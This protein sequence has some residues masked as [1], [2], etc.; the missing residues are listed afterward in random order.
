MLTLRLLGT[1]ELW[2]NGSLVPIERRKALALL[3]YLA[4]EPGAHSRERLATLL[5]PD[6]APPAARAGLRRALAE[7]TPTLRPWLIATNERIALQ[8]D[9]A[10]ALDVATFRQQVALPHERAAAVALYR[11]ELLAGFALPDNATFD[12]WLFFQR[13]RLRTELADALDQ[14]SRPEAG[15]PDY[16]PVLEYARR[17]IA[18]DPL[19][20]PAHRRLM[21]I[22][23]TA[24]QSTAALRHY[25]TLAETLE[26]ELGAVPEAATVTLYEQIKL[27]DR[28]PQSSRWSGAPPRLVLA[29]PLASTTIECPTLPF[30]GREAELARIA[31]ALDDPACR[32]LTLIGPG[33][34][35]KTRLALHATTQYQAHFPDGVHQISLIGVNSADRLLTTIC[36]ALGLVGQQPPLE[37]I[38]AALADRRVLL[39]LDNAD[40]ALDGAPLLHAL[41][42]RTR[43]LKLFVTSRERLQLQEEWVV[44]LEGLTVPD[45]TALHAAAT[46]SA[47]Q[48][49]VQRARQVQTGFVLTED[50]IPA[51][52]AICQLVEG[53]PLAVELA[54]AWVR[55]LTPAEIARELAQN[56][57]LL[58][59][60]LHDVPE[61][62]RSVEGVFAQAWERLSEAERQVVRQLSV[63]DDGFSRGAA[64][65]VA[66]ATPLLLASLTDKALIRRDRNGRYAIHELLR[67]YA[68]RRLAADPSEQQATLLRFCRFSMRLLE[69][70]GANLLNMHQRQALI[71]LEHEYDN[72]WQAWTWAIRAQRFAEL[73]QGLDGFYRLHELRGW[74]TDGIHMLE[75]ITRELAHLPAAQLLVARAR[76]RIG[77]LTCWIGQFA[78]AE[79]E[80]ATALPVLEAQ[81][82]LLDLAFAY[83]AMGVVAIERDDTLHAQESLQR[84]LET[85]QR[86]DHQPGIAWTLDALSDLAGST[87]DYERAT[88]LLNQSCTIFNALG[89]QVN[90]AW[91]LCNLGR[92]TGLRDQHAEARQLLAE[93]L[94]IFTV[95]GDRHGA[96]MAHANL[97][98]IA[99]WS[100]D[101][102]AARY[103]SE[104][105][106]HLAREVHALPLVLDTLVGTAQIAITTGDLTRAHELLALVVEQPATWQETLVTAQPLL[107]QTT[108]L[109]GRPA[110]AQ[111]TRRGRMMAWEE[112]VAREL[113][114][115]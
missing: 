47:I 40:H 59:T 61:R 29:A 51:V 18:L 108:A 79:A 8:R 80:L 15:Q 1:P 90:V 112:A 101:L 68:L 43:H 46:Y 75:L 84:G 25:R 103:H 91:S 72:L 2:A 45:K 102:G 99:N 115:V 64:S 50:L 66:Y 110:A 107:D 69:Q 12:E 42:Q 13:E 41:I 70:R 109:L 73:G 32:I 76:T 28:A 82:A 96:A 97:S 10:F 65:E 54:A 93:S 49:F 17:W 63:F 55:V 104:A 52:V 9:A 44:T 60:T 87:G 74:Y 113:G 71:E 105:A 77:A 67:Q 36:A 98:E 38:V 106:L 88:E 26:R 4:L 56:M 62:H 94:S 37:R 24:G 92:V 33:G 21:Q 30:L 89:D 86:L 22:Y 5:A 85:Y 7:L 81:Q 53:M 39:L 11:G 114:S 34:M 31:E 3:T 100:H 20:E 83:T 57:T 111:A 16:E 19:H 48:L 78:R 27:G 6:A 95:I 35:G 58:T 23:A 14:L